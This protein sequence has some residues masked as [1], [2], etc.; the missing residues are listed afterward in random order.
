MLQHFGDEYPLQL[1]ISIRYGLK[2]EQKGFIMN[3]RSK[4]VKV[5]EYL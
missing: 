1:W 5:N 2:N 4:K 3:S